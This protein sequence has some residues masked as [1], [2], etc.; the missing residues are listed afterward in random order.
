MWLMLGSNVVV[1]K[2]KSAGH[3]KVIE[4]EVLTPGTDTSAVRLSLSDSQLIPQ[5]RSVLHSQPPPKPAGAPPSKDKEKEKDKGKDKGKDKD[6]PVVNAGAEEGD[7]SVALTH[8]SKPKV[9]RGRPGLCSHSMRHAN[10]R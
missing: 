5:A 7:K 6:E 1:T 8:V 2:A 4:L 3:S 9:N 10:S